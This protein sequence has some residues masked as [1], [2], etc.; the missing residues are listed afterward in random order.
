M[1]SKSIKTTFQLPSATLNEAI[2]YLSERF[3]RSA[4][5]IR[6]VKSPNEYCLLTLCRPLV[7]P[8]FTGK[9]PYA[10]GQI[11]LVFHSDELSTAADVLMYDPEEGDRVL[12][13]K[14]HLDPP[15]AAPPAAPLS[16]VMQTL[17]RLEQQQQQLQATLSQTFRTTPE[18]PPKLPANQELMRGLSEAFQ[19]S[20]RPLLSAIAQ[21]TDRL[22]Q[23]E[24][25]VES[26]PSPAALPKLQQQLDALTQQL[27]RQH[28][29]LHGQLEAIAAQVVAL[30]GEV[31]TAPPVPQ[32]EAE[33]RSRIAR[34]QGTV[35]DYETYSTAYREM[36]ADAPLFDTPDWVMLCEL[37]WAQRLCPALAD[38]YTLL[39]GPNGVG[40]EGAD[41]LQQFGAHCRDEET[42]YLYQD[43][44]YGAEAAMQEIAHHPSY[45][46][47]PVLRKLWQQLKSPK[48]RVFQL[49]GWQSE[50]ITALQAIAKPPQWQGDYRNGGS[51]KSTAP[52]SLQD[53]RAMLNIGPFTPLTVETVKRA[54]RQ[55]MKTAHPDSGGSTHKAQQIN[56]AYQA[57]MRHYFS[58]QS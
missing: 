19:A 28:S 33:W 39:Y 47:L 55:A 46:W 35:G 21:L 8:W 11:T 38:L 25:K 40:D 6:V 49:F 30:G 14:P 51:S 48:H 3:L 56:E 27:D 22:Q 2:V 37:E 13:T 29:T 24:A 58:G 34:T 52:P 23:L 43:R 32:T 54:Y 10:P 18:A 4:R 36:H 1:P 57:V 42:Y 9:L 7:D 20:S 12:H 5:G 50:A 41:V 44:G 15:E 53:Y 26:Q 16:E 45:S 31:A 17:D